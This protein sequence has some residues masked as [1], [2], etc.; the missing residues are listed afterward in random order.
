MSI[1]SP[2]SGTSG[3][4]LLAVKEVHDEPGILKADLSGRL[5]EL[6]GLSSSTV[7][8]LLVEL[9]SEGHLTSSVAGTHAIYRPGRAH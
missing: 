5:Q 7:G 6:T 4:R 3:A 2:D 9:E 8:E 1:G